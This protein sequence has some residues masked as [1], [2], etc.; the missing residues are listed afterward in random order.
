MKRIAAPMVGGLVTSAFL[1]LEIIPVVYTYW[2]QEQLLHERLAAL[3]PAAHAALRR[4]AAVQQAGWFALA[5][6]A[7]AAFYLD[8]PRWALALAT[9]AATS[10]AVAGAVLY[11]PVRPAAARQVWPRRAPAPAAARQSA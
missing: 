9:A 11:L 5:G 4:L 6:V 3:D 8:L 7:A 1:T 10:V 2:R